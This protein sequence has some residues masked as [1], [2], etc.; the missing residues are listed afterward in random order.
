MPESVPRVLR[1]AA[2]AAVGVAFALGGACAHGGLGT[3][4]SGNGG[5]AGGGAITANGGSATDGSG[6]RAQGSGGHHPSSGGSSPG[7][8]GS[9]GAGGGSTEQACPANQFMTGFGG[10]GTLACAPLDALTKSQVNTGC[11]IYAGWR[12]TC[13]ACLTPPAKWGQVSGT[14][15]TN[16]AGVDDTCSTFPLGGQSVGMFGLNPDGNVNDD[17]K[18]YLTLHCTP[19]AATSGNGPCAADELVSG[20]SGSNVTCTKASA[21][22]LGFVRS[23]CS[24]YY[25]ISDGCTGC[26]NPP[27]KWGFAG[28]SGCQNGAG[29]DSTCI[30]TPLG[31][32]SVNLF[33]LNP[34]GDVD[35]NDKIFVG[36]HC[37][38]AM[39]TTS[40][41]ASA[42]PA[43]QFVTGVHANGKVECASP[44]PA[45]A[46]AFATACHLYF[47]WQDSCDGCVTP[48]TKWGS[49]T[50]GACALGAGVNDTCSQ[51]TLGGKAV[52]LFGLNPGG[53]VDDNDKLHFGF[54]CY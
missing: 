40:Q 42:C 47:G 48:P 22:V 41:A 35:S 8:G 14:A 37:E 45:V 1:L 5:S 50:T 29:A 39:A 15:C 18:L 26:S 44:A 43:G 34:D 6:G 25:G 33:G 31:S 21:A 38:P 2:W 36:L 9:G 23:S 51:P 20:V 53:D 10:G 52:N 19:G 16:G 7:A 32:E 46:A 24:V 49:V 4:P 54:V 27:T 13:D 28:D 17:D 11:S 30:T 3:G 12:D